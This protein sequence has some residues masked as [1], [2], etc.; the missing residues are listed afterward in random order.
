MEQKRKESPCFT[1]QKARDKND[2]SGTF[3]YLHTHPKT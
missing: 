2:S 1:E 3:F